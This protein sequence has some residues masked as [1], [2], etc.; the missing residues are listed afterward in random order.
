M[1]EYGLSLI[2]IFPTPGL[3]YTVTSLSLLGSVIIKT[4]KYSSVQN[5]KF[6]NS[7]VHLQVDIWWYDNESKQLKYTCISKILVN[8]KYLQ[9]TLAQSFYVYLNVH[10]VVYGL[11]NTSHKDLYQNNR[12]IYIFA[13]VNT[14][15]IH[16][17]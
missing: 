5:F 4:W 14:H 13:M 11:N 10:P 9:T 17:I 16:Y 1:A 7:K 2:R 12:D 6:K 3:F 8:K 15:H